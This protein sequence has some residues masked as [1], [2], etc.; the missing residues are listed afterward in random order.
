PLSL[1]EMTLRHMAKEHP[2]IKLFYMSGD[3]VP[4]TIWSSS[5]PE[6]TKVIEECSKLIYKYFPN[7][8]VLFLVGNHEA[9]PVNCF[10]P[11]G[12][13]EKIDTRWIYNVSYDAWKTSIPNDQ[14]SRYL[15]E[16]SYTVEISK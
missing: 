15:E 5:I 9:H 6:N 2:D 3:I 16:G 14:V 11:P 8:K 7:T 12:V 4:H 1:L 10:S 13:P